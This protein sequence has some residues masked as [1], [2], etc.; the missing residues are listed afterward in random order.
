MNT[1]L[2][3]VSLVIQFL[4]IYFVIVSFIPPISLSLFYGNEHKHRLCINVRKQKVY[5][6]C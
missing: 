1:F 2:H 5:I 3:R 6:K 4:N